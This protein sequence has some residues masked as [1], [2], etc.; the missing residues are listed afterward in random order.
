MCHDLGRTARNRRRL[1][2]KRKPKPSRVQVRAYF[3]ADG[4]SLIFSVLVA[5]KVAQ[6]VTSALELGTDVLHEAP[7]LGVD[8][9]QFQD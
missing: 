2:Q 4:R 5:Q 8:L 6:A 9:L 1:C 3:I 7:F